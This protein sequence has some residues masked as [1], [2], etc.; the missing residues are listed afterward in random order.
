MRF[1]A[2]LFRACLT[3]LPFLVS[4]ATARASVIVVSGGDFALNV[5]VQAA[6]DGDTLLVHA[7]N[8]YFFDVDG[9]SLS[10]LAYPGETVNLGSANPPGVRVRNLAA[11]QTCVVSGFHTALLQVTNCAGAVRIAG[12]S[13]IT[14]GL[15]CS[16]TVT[17]SLD[18]SLS[19]CSFRGRVNPGAIPGGT[20][21]SISSSNVALYDLSAIGANGVTLVDVFGAPYGTAGGNGL[22]VDS[23]SIFASNCIF[24]GGNGANGGTPP[25][26]PCHQ[27]GA[28]G[29]GV[30][31]G[32]APSM[33]LRLLNVA[34]SGGTGGFGCGV[35]SPAGS[36]INGPSSAV[37]LLS[38]TRRALEAPS[39]RR[40]GT[41]FP[42]TF[43]G[44]IGDRV[45][46]VTS[47]RT[48]WSYEPLFSGVVLY[49]PGVRRFPMGT[50]GASGALTVN[51]TAPTLPAGVEATLLHMQAVCVDTN[52]SPRLS[53]PVTEVFFDSAF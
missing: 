6:A 34:T 30:L 25:P 29:D 44:E 36:P 27:G 47:A 17:G 52:G 4:L 33:Q 1:A 15:E 23:S 40:E 51:F 18:V 10:I 21:L 31:L 42:I 14:A 50:I 32:S 49:G 9:K 37:T 20:A 48:Q 35:Q 19:G 45:I 43:R 26:F 8:Y 11:G 5:A 12:V 24:A 39:P 2:L 22:A 13:S 46:L 41:L 53:G 16:A 7:G 3:T 28:G 38:G